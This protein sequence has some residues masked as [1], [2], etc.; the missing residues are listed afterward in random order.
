MCALM[1]ALDHS[2][3]FDFNHLTDANSEPLITVAI[4]RHRPIVVRWLL[5]HPMV[6][7]DIADV[8]SITPLHTAVRMPSVFSYL[9]RDRCDECAVNAPDGH[10]RTALFLT[11]DDTV[12]REGTLDLFRVLLSRVPVVDID[13]PTQTVQEK[14]RFWSL[15]TQRQGRTGS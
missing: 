7:L 8:A 13:V 3:K 15:R 12:N 14:K 1:R 10:G 6:R 9:V 11:V 2:T 4:R 5:A